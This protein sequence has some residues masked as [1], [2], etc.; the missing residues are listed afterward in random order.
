M[1]SEPTQSAFPQM[2]SKVLMKALSAWQKEHSVVKKDADG[3][4]KYASLEVV[5]HYVSSAANCGLAHYFISRLI[6]LKKAAPRAQ[7]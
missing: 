3:R 1:D 7:K 5:T 4:F 6:L 2:G